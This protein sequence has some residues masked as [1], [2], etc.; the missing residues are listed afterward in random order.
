VNVPVDKVKA[1][2]EQLEQ[3]EDEEGGEMLQL[4]QKDYIKHIEKMHS[5]L[6]TAWNTEQRVK[7]LKISIKVTCSAH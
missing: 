3:F 7:A 1:R 5:D 6:I 4:T 2:L